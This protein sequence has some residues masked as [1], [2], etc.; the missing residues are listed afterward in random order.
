MVAMPG[1]LVAVADAGDGT[2]KL[3]SYDGQQT[4]S[5]NRTFVFGLKRRIIQLGPVA[6]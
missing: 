3:L 1:G 6:C 5:Y 4:L 2:I